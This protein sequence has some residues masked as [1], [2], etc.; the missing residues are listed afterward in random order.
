MKA[1]LIALHISS[2]ANGWYPEAYEMPDMETC[3]RSVEAAKIDIPSGGDAE[4][5][6]A[7]FCVTSL[8]QSYWY[9]TDGSFH[10]R[11]VEQP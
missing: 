5:A 4:A 2:T 10:R 1:F 9:G 7:L 8:D 11:E 6:I 3:L